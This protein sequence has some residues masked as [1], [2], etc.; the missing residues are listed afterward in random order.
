MTSRGKPRTKTSMGRHDYSSEQSLDYW[1]T[2]WKAEFDALPERKQQEYREYLALLLETA[3][4]RS[5]LWNVATCLGITK[6]G[7]GDGLGK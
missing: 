1:C 4:S 3:P 7:G 2:R 5:Q 6:G